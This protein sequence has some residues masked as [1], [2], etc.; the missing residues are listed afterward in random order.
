MSRIIASRLA[1]RSVVALGQTP[2]GCRISELAAILDAPF[3]SVE[4]ALR[5]LAADEVVE[6]RAKR[7]QLVSSH[8]SDALIQLALSFLEP[9]EL[10]AAVSGANPAVE[11]LGHDGTGYLMVTRR[12]ADPVDEAT[13]SHFLARLERTRDVSVEVIEKGALREAL[14]LDDSPRRRAQGMHVIRGSVD[15]SFPDRSRHGDPGAP[16]LGELHPSL[17]TPS[18]RRLKDLARRYHLRR[19]SVFGSATRG[20]FR[21]D[22]DVDLVIEPRDGHRIRLGE[23]VRLGSEVEDLFARDVD[24]LAA[25]IKPELR[26]RIDRDGVVLYDATR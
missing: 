20:D 26:A 8:R 4:R 18:Q 23:F 10:L 11:F 7:Y 5:L 14:T 21:P 17:P 24:L 9:V 2:D 22:S 13:L 16:P 1:L 3:T 25:P 15:R 12:F 6:R 19:L